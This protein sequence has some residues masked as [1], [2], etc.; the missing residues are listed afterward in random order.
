MVNSE[1]DSEADC[2]Q[3]TELFGMCKMG[4][5]TKLAGEA[6]LDGLQLKMPCNNSISWH[7]AG[8]VPLHACPQQMTGM[9]PTTGAAC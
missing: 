9:L 2:A 7:S 6:I 8:T 4:L 1:D 5:L 3:Q